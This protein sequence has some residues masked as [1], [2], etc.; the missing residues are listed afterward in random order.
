MAWLG[1]SSETGAQLLAI[2][3]LRWQLFRNSL[4]TIRGRL[5]V[6]SRV[7]VG[8]VMG[9]AWLG[10]GIGL[11]AG[12]YFLVLQGK[13]QW[14]AGL[15]WVVFLF[16][17]F[18]PLLASAFTIPFEFTN[19]LRFPI[20]FS[21]F[22]LLAL[23]YGLFDPASV[24][25]CFWLACIAAGIAFARPVLL[26][27]AMPVLV[28]FAA[29]NLLLGRVVLAWLERW[30]AQRRTREVMA[31]IFFLFMISFQLI[32]PLVDR[33]GHRVGP[34]AKR[35]ALLLPLELI[36]PPG[37]VGGAL[38]QG[39]RGNALQ[40]AGL[41]AGLGVY[42]LLFLWL[43]RI[44][45][46][47]QYRG[48]NLSEAVAPAT[49]P[50]AQ[51]VRP[52]WNLPRLSEPVAAVFEKEFRYLFRSG[53]IVFTM[54]MPLF[55]LVL[56]R[57]MPATPR[58][59]GNPFTSAPDLAFPIVTAYALLML[60]NL[61]YNSLGA[62]GTGIQ[63]LFAAPVR[64]RDVLWA[65]NLAHSAILGLEVA[66]A[67]L[68]VCVMFRPPS[69]SI[70]AAT[71]AGLLFALPVNLLAGNLLSLYAPRKFDLGAFGRQRAS[72]ITVFISLGT[73][74]VTVGLAAGT[75]LLARLYGRLWIA[76]VIFLVLA[77]AAG[78]AY[79]LVLD[80]CSRIALERREV[81]VAELCKQ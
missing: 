33:W 62:D 74:V 5:E 79:F 78:W 10:V 3:T 9:T 43:L 4:R 32:G 54:V 47:A 53:P 35:L 25:G 42:V 21:S 63:F 37:L 30:L 77:A 57:L 71:L 18:F 7:F 39:A 24:G 28:A 34:M 11:G 75:L 61:V 38:A 55:I 12:A 13:T 73:Q 45:L 50:L 46:R 76:V 81:L 23:A 2:A 58:N 70:V 69:L 65:K 36:L 1:S 22:F 26:L 68:A 20:R 60:T 44:R 72:G 49:V 16:W 19:L 52:G 8:L 51:A 27:W 6:I 56:F 80:R 15:L 64:F 41:A 14:L 29:V 31:I 40:A 17:Q 59:H 66:L 48:E 67:W